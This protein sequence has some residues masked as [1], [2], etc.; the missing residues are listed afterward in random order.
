[1][2]IG[3]RITDLEQTSSV[4]NGANYLV[5]TAGGTM[6]IRQDD[7]AKAIGKLL[8]LGNL[9]DL[10]TD[11]KTSL[12]NAINEIAQSSSSEFKG[13][14]GVKAGEKGLVPA[15]IASDKDYVLS[16]SGV[17][18]PITA[19]AENV[20]FEDGKNAQEKLGNIDGITDDLN[21][22]NSRIAAS[23]KAL[24]TVNDS[25]SNKPI[26]IYQGSAAIES[27]NIQLNSHNFSDFKAIT[28]CISYFG[29]R[30]ALNFANTETDGRHGWFFISYEGSNVRMFSGYLSFSKNQITDVKLRMSFDLGAFNSVNPTYITVTKILG[31]E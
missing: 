31:W 3:R 19:N 27:G 4:S 17:W 28:I 2:A 24:K 1:M 21:S 13:T 29:S 15:P 16:A 7:L 20:K 25:L 5:E 18:V 23:S 6:R 12:V 22:E 26:I 9:N 30:Y 8:S 14:N 10:D 11:D